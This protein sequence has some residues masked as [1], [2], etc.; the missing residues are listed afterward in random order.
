MFDDIDSNGDGM[1]TFTE[2][3][4]LMIELVMGTSDVIYHRLSKL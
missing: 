2:F 1:I 4:T 3:K